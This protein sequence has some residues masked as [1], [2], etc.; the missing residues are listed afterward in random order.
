MRKNSIKNT[1]VNAEVQRELSNI[2]RGGIKDPRVSPMTSVVAV[3]VAP[4]LKT[5]KAYISVLGDE[6][7]QQDTIKG[8]QSA[9][10]FIR[11]ELART[12]NM[13]NTPE[14]KF[15]V[16]QSIEY[17]VNISKKIDEVTKD[18][19]DEAGELMNSKKIDLKELLKEKKKIALGGHVRPDGD[20]IG[21]VMGLYLYLKQE[22]PHIQTDVYLEKIPE[23]FR[24]IKG[25]DEVR[26][27][28]NNNETPY[29]LFICLDCADPM[30][31]G[32]SSSVFEN[33][34]E[35]VCIDHHISNESFADLNYIVPDASSTS[36]LVVTLLDEEKISKESAEA[37]Y[38][39]I[40]HDTGVFRYSCTSPETMEN[41]AKLMRKGINGN[42]IIEQTFYEKTYVQNQI[43]GRALLESM[44]IMDR[45]CV[46]S[47]I[48]KSSMEFFHAEPSDLEGVVSILRQ[49]KGVE[50]AIFLH[51]LEPQKYKVSLRSK[52]YIDVSVI[53]KHFGG[54]GHIR[55]AGVTMTGSAHDVI[56]NITE[57]IAR[58]FEK[59]EEKSVIP[60]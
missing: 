16:D 33:A 58:Q 36:E 2:L 11:R 10:G 22:Y 17:G 53:A 15:I 56:N 20:C 40:A 49:T 12:I 55:A 21:S 44:L 14:I 7:A 31:L 57:Q 38:M 18:L 59:L 28:V 6:K 9:E 42:A 39:G 41:A 37:L 26:S 34:K 13:R 46:V 30:R 8:L 27:E 25:T 29:D 51:E 1:R 47:V 52:Q 32:F 43:L 3:E 5:C 24:L 4:D 23:T 54:G 19:K 45:Q 50:V 48:R 35:T 60:Q